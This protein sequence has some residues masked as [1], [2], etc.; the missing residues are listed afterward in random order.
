[1]NDE[2][3]KVSELPEAT[4]LTENDY[5]MIVQN[6]INKKIKMSNLEFLQFTEEGETENE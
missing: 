1:M 5:F 4:E 3:I 2:E 6:G